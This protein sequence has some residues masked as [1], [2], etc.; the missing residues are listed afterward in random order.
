MRNTSN[1]A[2]H[3]NSHLLIQRAV[4]MAKE[5]KFISFAFLV[6]CDNTTITTMYAIKQ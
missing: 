1:T 6:V 2:N 5:N 3:I 4:Y